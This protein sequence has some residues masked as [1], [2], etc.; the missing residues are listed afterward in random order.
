MADW[1][2]QSTAEQREAFHAEFPYRDDFTYA[3]ARAWAHRANHLW[4]GTKTLH[5]V[6][7]VEGKYVV[8]QDLIQ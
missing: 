6:E 1:K 2:F 7:C 5:T 4:R 3:E 8:V